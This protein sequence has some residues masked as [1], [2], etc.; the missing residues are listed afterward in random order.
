MTDKEYTD[1]VDS[2]KYPSEKFI[3]DS[4]GYGLAQWTYW[5]RKYNL[6]EFAKNKKK[7]SI[8]NLRMQLE[9]FWMEVN[10][11][12]NLL[13]K[14]KNATSILE[15]SNAMLHIYEKPAD[16]SAAVEAKRAS[17][18]ETFYKLYAK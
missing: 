8:G 4:A 15:A 7:S 14:L 10:A 2:G 1:A 9:F 16:Q 12:K 3:R 6:Y 17:Y 18:G 11:N 13:S 5:S